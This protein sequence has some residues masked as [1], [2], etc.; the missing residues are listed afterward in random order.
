MALNRPRDGADSGEELVLDDR[1]RAAFRYPIVSFE[2]QL[3]N[4]IGNLV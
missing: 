4:M 3:L 1:Q 2:K